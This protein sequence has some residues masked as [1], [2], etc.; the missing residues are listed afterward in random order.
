MRTLRTLVLGIVAGAL[1]APAAIAADLGGGPARRGSIKDAPLPPSVPLYSWSGL[2]IGAHVGYGWSDLDWTAGGATS[3]DNGGG[4]LGGAQI[5]YN[6]QRG[7]LVFGVEADISSG[8][9]GTTSCPAPAFSCS[10]DVNWLA[11]VRGRLGV[12]GNGNRT[13][14]YATAGG[15]WADVDYSSTAP[16]TTGFSDRQFGWVAGGGIEHMLT[17]NMSAR[18][19]YLYYGFDSVTAPAGT[20]SGGATALDPSMQTVRLGLNVKF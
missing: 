4:W 20:L 12:A 15:A 1:L 11:S 8:F 9:D 16:G 2:Y 14:F 7:A 5:G 17:P 18:V 10:H 6:W 3:S 19:E 13:L